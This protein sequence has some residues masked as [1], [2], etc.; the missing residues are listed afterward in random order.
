MAKTLAHLDLLNGIVSGKLVKFYF[1]R[2][3]SLAS[4][5]SAQIVKTMELCCL[6]LVVLEAIQ[7]YEALFSYVLPKPAS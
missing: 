2:Y 7:G 3:A 4:V 1:V 6:P 5:H